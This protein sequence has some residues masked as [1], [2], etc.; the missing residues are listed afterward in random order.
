MII[1]WLVFARNIY[2]V[3]LIVELHRESK[4]ISYTT[5]IKKKNF[6]IINL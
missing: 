5:Y 6:K 2:I 1:K 4:H 3:C